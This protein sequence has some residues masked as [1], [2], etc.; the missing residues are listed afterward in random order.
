MLAYLSNRPAVAERGSNPNL[1][2]AVIAVHVAGVAALMS[3]KMDF[4]V[5]I[6]HPPIEVDLIEP[7]K[8][9]PPAPREQT[10]SA[11]QPRTTVFT[12][13]PFVPIDDDSPVA[14]EPSPLPLPLPVD[15]V[16]QPGAGS[17]SEAK[18][19]PATPAVLMTGAAE[20]KPPYPE[21]RLASGEEATLKLRL[22]IAPSGRV[23]AVE[24]VGRSDKV[25][26]AAAR[27][28]ILAHWRYRPARQGGH[29]VT[30][31]VV[32]SLRFQ[33]DG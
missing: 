3:A 26:L 22:T 32:I 11:E 2:L 19:I 9:Q 21:A 31:T 4:P 15:P 1:M 5:K 20:L 29:D 8:P 30:S 12:P 7:A 13:D 23:I 27:N 28:H 25:F 10:K 24:A 18:P 17:G 16:P 33:L 6:L 14:V